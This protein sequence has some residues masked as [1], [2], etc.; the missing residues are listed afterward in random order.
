MSTSLKVSVITATYNSEKYVESAIKS[1]INQSYKNIEYI[2][3]DGASKDNTLKIVE[4]YDSKIDKLISEEDLGIYDAFN[5]G[6]RHATGDIIYFLNSDDTLSDDSVIEEVV[7]LFDENPN[8][9]YVYGNVQFLENTEDMTV[10]GREF[11]VQ[12]FQ[13]GYAP[14][15]QAVFVK[16][17]FFHQYGLFNLEYAVAGDFEFSLRCFLN[18]AEKETM[19]V[20]KV[21][22]NFRIGGVSS[23][24]KTRIRGLMEKEKIINHYFRVSTDFT[25][26]EIQNNALFRTWFEI[27]LLQNKGI[28]RVLKKYEINNVAIFGTLTTCKYLIKDLELENL[29]IKGILDN[30]ENMQDKKILGYDIKPVQ[31]VKENI[32]LVDAI[33]VS[34]E[35]SRDKEVIK[36][37]NDAF[38]DQIKVFSWK[39]LIESYASH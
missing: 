33:I 34:I 37:L 17:E 38:A 31:W 4:N 24:Y 18:A 26:V 21:L 1:V 29:C 30:N 23:S 35:S 12:D 9:W 32:K 16:A 3:I 15:H 6:I 39:D 36:F 11:S 25:S 20:N 10:Y 28:S 2:I 13:K 22:A 8:T 5:K 27:L 19:Y 14:P 7:S